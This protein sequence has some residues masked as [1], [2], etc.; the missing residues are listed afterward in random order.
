V[1][2]VQL[3]VGRWASTRFARR[4]S[5]VAAAAQRWVLARYWAGYRARQPSGTVQPWTE[6]TCH[7]RPTDCDALAT[8]TEIRAQQGP[9]VP[10]MTPRRRSGSLGSPKTRA[11]SP[12]ELP[13]CWTYLRQCSCLDLEDSSGH[14]TGSRIAALALSANYGQ[15]EPSRKL[16]RNTARAKLVNR[17]SKGSRPARQSGG[18]LAHRATSIVCTVGAC[19]LPWLLSLG[20]PQGAGNAGQRNGSG[21]TRR[22]PRGSGPTAIAC[23]HR[24]AIAAGTRDPPKSGPEILSLTPQS[25]VA[26][27]G[28]LT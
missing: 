11:E 19:P 1:R 18:L 20:L 7:R 26:A 28:G 15:S 13:Q 4:S 21:V 2:Q 25:A 5:A 6:H 8:A 14:S 10:S 27:G 12:L 3:T 22:I 17:T 16:D 9:Q 23:C 24:A